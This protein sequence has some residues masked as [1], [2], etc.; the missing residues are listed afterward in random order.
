[1]AKYKKRK[2]GD[3][4]KGTDSEQSSLSL[5]DTSLSLSPLPMSETT[6]KPIS[7]PVPVPLQDAVHS[8]SSSI[9]ENIEITNSNS[10]SNS[11]NDRSLQEI[12]IGNIP[13][14]SPDL[15]LTSVVNKPQLPIEIKSS[16]Q[17]S[18]ISDC[19]VIS[20]NALEKFENNNF[21]DSSHAQNILDEIIKND[22]F[23]S[24]CDS[25][26]SNPFDDL[27]SITLKSERITG[28]ENKASQS[29]SKNKLSEEVMANKEPIPSQAEIDSL[30]EANSS[31]PS[32]ISTTEYKQYYDKV[33]LG[34]SFFL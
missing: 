32:T 29:D 10:N 12:V 11:E 8:E 4:D 20:L 9:S 1:M 5:S 23:D 15:S 27:S 16:L 14:D 30:K 24:K 28:C 31:N 7:V 2:S 26:Q 19:S 17:N 6:N 21:L 13:L 25:I 33:N 34:V 18:L 22:S 3:K